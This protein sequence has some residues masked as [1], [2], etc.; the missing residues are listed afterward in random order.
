MMR[1]LMNMR[2]LS[3]HSEKSPYPECFAF[4]SLPSQKHLQCRVIVVPAEEPG[5]TDL[6]A[7]HAFADNP[8]DP[9]QP[10]GLP[11][12][13]KVTPCFLK[14]F[15]GEGRAQRQMRPDADAA[16]GGCIFSSGHP[17]QRYPLGG[18]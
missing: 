8:L 4:R 18:A 9:G 1:K 11:G 2:R 7:R 5:S 10:C 17:D 6:N 12:R 15:A 16:R 13:Q 14:I 3:A